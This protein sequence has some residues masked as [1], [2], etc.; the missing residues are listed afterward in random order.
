MPTRK[1]QLQLCQHSKQFDLVRQTWFNEIRGLW[2]VKGIHL[3][4][5]VFF[6][7]L[8]AIVLAGCGTYSSA[9]PVSPT[10]PTPTPPPPPP[11]IPGARPEVHI[12]LITDKMTFD[13]KTILAPADARI[14]INFENKDNV[15]HNFALYELSDA[16]TAFFIGQ[17][18]GPNQ[19]ITYEFIA[20]PS[21]GTYFFRCDLHPQTMTGEFIIMG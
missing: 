19:S 11:I 18:A 13:R 7:A 16:K 2:R 14:F 21:A 4:K 20:P 17:A 3:V 1:L 15:W 5:L 8:L 9:K 10:L 6:M 12:S